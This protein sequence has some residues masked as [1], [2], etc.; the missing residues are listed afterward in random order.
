MNCTAGVRAGVVPVATLLVAF[1]MGSLRIVSAARSSDGASRCQGLAAAHL[2]NTTITTAEAVRDGS[3]TPPGATA[4]ITGLPAFCRVAGEIHPTSDSH[5]GFEVWLPMEGWNKKVAAA[6]NA[7]WAG[8]IPYDY[9]GTAAGPLIRNAK[10]PFG[11]T[12]SDQLKRG[13]ATAA[14]DTG[15]RLGDGGDNFVAFAVG[16][17]ERLVDF[18][19]RAV[20][21]TAV[22]AKALVVKFYGRAP[23]H[24]YWV[25]QSTGGEQGLKEAERFPDDYDG[26]VVG[27]PSPD[28][29]WTDVRIVQTTIA[30]VNSSLDA[31]HR[32]LL[33]NAVVA[34]CDADDGVLDSLISDPPRC[35]FDPGSLECRAGTTDTQSCLTPVQ[36][37]AVRRVYDGLRDPNTGQLLAA[38]PAKGSELLWGQSFPQD[39]LRLPTLS[40]MRSVVFQ[41]PTWDWRTFDFGRASDHDVV[42]ER[43]RVI[44]SILN[45][46]NPDLR[47][48]K[49]RGG[50]ILHFNGWTDQFV[51]ESPAYYDSV[52]RTVGGSKDV[53]T[54]LRQ[55]QGFYR[56]FMVPGMIHGLGN[57]YG[58]ATFDLLTALEDWVERGK[59]PDLLEATEFDDKASPVRSRPLCSYPS[60]ARYRGSG[61]VNQAASFSCRE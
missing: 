11:F 29:T 57:G 40:Y 39:G 42:M 3:F 18:G 16:H 25:G 4:A 34:A 51:R 2:T 56:L 45:A 1:A 10:V 7:G 14:T 27:T 52:V 55:V 47:T 21:E 8:R 23:Q 15:H 48:F 33:H 43:E 20:H 46:D 32:S 17:P 53:Q 5:I 61:D 35:G 31:T 58:P 60:V 59:A 49:R 30:L 6:G 28:P 41:N 22:I 38:G 54:A 12:L 13:Y 44:R 24:A 26:M 19:Y 36:V 37:A 50:K 9:T